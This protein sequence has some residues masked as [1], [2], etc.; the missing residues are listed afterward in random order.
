MGLGE[1]AGREQGRLNSAGLQFQRSAG[2]RHRTLTVEV[3]RVEVCE[4]CRQEAITGM[5]TVNGE[6]M[7]VCE[8]CREKLVQRTNPRTT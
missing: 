8:E 4:N 3:W 5:A 2:W 6:V 7:R 1:G